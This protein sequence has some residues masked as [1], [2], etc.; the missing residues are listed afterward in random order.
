MTVSRALNNSP[1]VAEETRRKVLEVAARLGYQIN[2][3]ARGLATGLTMTV[4][5]L[6]PFHH[7]RAIESWYTSQLMHDIRA[8]LWSLGFDS[9][10]A[11][12][13]LV[14][15]DLADI[16]RLVA[17]KKVDGLVVIGYEITAEAIGA[18]AELTDRYVAVN[19]PQEPWMRDRPA[20]FVD[21]RLGGR[22]AAEAL[23]ERGCST[24]GI[25]TEAKPQFQ[26]RAKGFSDGWSGSV[27]AYTLDDGTFET[28]YGF[29]YDQWSRLAASVDG[30]FVG[31]DISALGVTSGLLERGVRVPHDIAVIGFDDIEWAQYN[32]PSL[33]TVHQPRR[34]VAELA[35]AMVTNSIRGIANPEISY[36]LKPRVVRRD[37][38]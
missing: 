2:A 18:L 24:V 30:L 15:D 23:V 10:I 26:D 35:A 37:S 19:P 6:Y 8:H 20:V 16:T 11:G 34:E 14:N 7:L 36:V 38:C 9:T 13:D 22:M 21:Q 1:L 29:A 33:S 28:A 4:G 31:S 17:Q 5:I 32:R 25:V 12:Y 3:G 27:S